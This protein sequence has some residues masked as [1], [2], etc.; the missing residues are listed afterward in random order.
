MNLGNGDLT[1]HWE[2]RGIKWEGGNRGFSLAEMH[3]LPSEF[4][5]PADTTRHIADAK[6]ARA[7]AS[8]DDPD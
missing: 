5:I 2:L 8:P 1:R 4:T 7:R 6:K 3:S